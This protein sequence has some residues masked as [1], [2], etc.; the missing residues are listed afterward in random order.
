MKTQLQIR[1][2]PKLIEEFAKENF[3]LKT[4]TGALI[5]FML[6]NSLVLAF[7]LRRGPMVVPLQ[8]DGNI[9]RVDSQVTDAQIQAAVKAYLSARYT[10]TDSTINA[11]LKRAEF[12]VAP[13]LVSA[14]QKAMVET[15][16]YVH[17]KK[18]NQRVYER[19]IEV[20]FKD[21]LA[22]VIA[23]RITEF[24]GLKAAT[25]MRLFLNFDLQDRTVVNP[26]GIFI[27]KET[28]KGPQ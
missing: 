14:F 18:V 16:K 9:A 17:E 1:Q 19:S 6:I 20:N 8:A 2:Y 10:W 27:T 24:D 23:D 12:F 21:H 25:E 5:A 15:L 4:L 13:Q 22:T 11:Q 3:N 26:W 7:L 28:E